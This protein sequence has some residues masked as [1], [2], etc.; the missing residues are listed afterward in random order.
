MFKHP[1]KE[2]ELTGERPEAKKI[3]PN[4]VAN[5]ASEKN[6]ANQLKNEAKKLEKET[7]NEEIM[8]KKPEENALETVKG[9]PSKP[10]KDQLNR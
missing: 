6:T 8:S 5:S 1:K 3:D 10:T 7:K 9:N 2:V 4:E